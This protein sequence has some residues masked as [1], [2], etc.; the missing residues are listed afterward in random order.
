[1]IFVVF[2]HICL[3]TIFFGVFVLV[4]LL[5]YLYFY[6]SQYRKFL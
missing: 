6:H 4:D 3:R 5:V 1:M 2:L